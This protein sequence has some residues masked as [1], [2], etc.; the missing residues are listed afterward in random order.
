[1]LIPPCSW[2]DSLEKKVRELTLKEASSKPGRIAQAIRGAVP[3][4]PL[5]RQQKAIVEKLI[6]MGFDGPLG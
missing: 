4:R 6:R 2:L 3:S 1:M 5:A